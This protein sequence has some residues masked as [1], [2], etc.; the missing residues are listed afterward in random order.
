MTSRKSGIDPY[1]LIPLF[2]FRLAIVYLIVMLAM[3]L[4]SDWTGWKT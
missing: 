2:L 4:I 1:W 3:I